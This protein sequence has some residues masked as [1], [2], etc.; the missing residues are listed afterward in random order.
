MK[1][2]YVQE[3]L[4][5]ITNEKIV[6]DFMD[7]AT[8]DRF[9]CAVMEAMINVGGINGLERLKEA[10]N[11]Q[12]FCADVYLFADYMMIARGESKNDQGARK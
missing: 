4:A 2:N 10:R 1:P 9:A 3:M 12:L 5:E 7:G 8:R 11:L 6:Q